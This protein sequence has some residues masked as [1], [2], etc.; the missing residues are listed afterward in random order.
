MI[1]NLMALILRT[2]LLSVWNTFREFSDEP[3]RI[4]FAQPLHFTFWHKIQDYCIYL[5]WSNPVNLYVYTYIRTY[6]H[7][8]QFRLFVLLLSMNFLI[9]LT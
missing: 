8:V 1:L 5:V 3:F 2:N 7:V 9:I 4:T 6:I